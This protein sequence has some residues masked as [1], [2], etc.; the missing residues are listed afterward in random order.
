MATKR[1]LNACAYSRSRLVSGRVPDS[2]CPGSHFD[3]R[4][5]TLDLARRLRR[6]G[7]L[8]LAVVAAGLV[9]A[10]LALATA[11]LLTATPTSLS[12]GSVDTRDVSP[13]KVVTITNTDATTVT[14]QGVSAG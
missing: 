9:A 6:W 13:R 8:G 10:A 2:H 12:F 1:I 11:S 7:L 14:V 3:R 5:G 4:K